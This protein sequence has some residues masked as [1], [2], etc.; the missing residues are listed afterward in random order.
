MDASGCAR[1]VA[2]AHMDVRLALGQG[3]AL[4]AR[5]TRKSWDALGPRPGMAVY[6][7]VKTMAIDRHSVA[8]DEEAGRE[9]V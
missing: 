8:G 4:W 3:T 6:A 7:L 2:G 1:A 9:D 5:I